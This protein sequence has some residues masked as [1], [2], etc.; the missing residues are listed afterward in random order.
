MASIFA[1][2]KPTRTES[3]R[4]LTTARSRHCRAA[5]PLDVARLE[6]V[7]Q[8]LIACRQLL[9]HAL[10]EASSVSSAELC[11]CAGYQA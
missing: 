2:S 4:R 5:R 8:D 9:D 11:I 6:G 10:K 7:L 3:R 1:C